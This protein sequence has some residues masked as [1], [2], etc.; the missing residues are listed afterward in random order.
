MSDARI[1]RLEQEVRSLRRA[2]YI[3]AALSLAL[4]GAVIASC[5]KTPAQPTQLS[6]VDGANKV[7]IDAKGITVTDAEHRIS[8]AR[9]NVS[10]DHV[11]VLASTKDSAA[12]SVEIW[13]HQVAVTVGGMQASLG[14]ADKL[15]AR[16]QLSSGTN[17]ADVQAGPTF[18]AFS[19]VT[20]HGKVIAETSIDAASIGV[21]HEAGPDGFMSARKDSICTRFR[22]GLPAAA[23]ESK[24]D[25]WT[26]C[27]P[28]ERD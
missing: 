22:R 19:L 5:A 20:P 8:L 17:R 25:T 15:G 6:F 28:P 9:G 12:G 26:M 14:V 3:S 24:G 16:L 7:E 18:S 1:D 10:A 21:E 27:A 2:L 4:G 11:Q 13:P 23:K